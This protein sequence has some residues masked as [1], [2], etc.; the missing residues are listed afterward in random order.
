MLVLKLTHVSKSGPMCCWWQID[1]WQIKW[2]CIV[3]MYRNF[4]LEVISIEC[5]FEV[6][7]MVPT[8]NSLQPRVYTHSHIHTRARTR[9]HNTTQRTQHI[10][11][12]NTLNVCRKAEKDYYDNL[13]QEN[14]NDI[15]KSWKI[16]RS[17]INNKKN[18]NRNEIFHIENADVTDK[19]TIANKFNEFY[20]NIEAR[21][22]RNI[23]PGKCEPINYIKIGISNSIFIHPVN[24][25]EVVAILKE[26]KNSSPGWDCIS[27]KI[28]K[29]TYRCFLEPLVHITNMSILHGVFPDEL[30]IAKVL[31]LYKGGAS[32]LLVN[33]RPM[34]VL[35]VF[36][37]VL[38]RLMYNRI[39]EFIEENDVLY[40][41]QFGFRKNHSTAIVLTIVNDKISK[42]LY[43]G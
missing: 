38:E 8:D 5:W 29:Q 9:K 33:Y 26:M 1:V 12:H 3:V 14:K 32:K 37:E 36:S 42:A 27:P 40:N 17:I 24:E 20:V 28:V 6:W 23:P 31:P 41:F 30:K 13:F 19:Q 18:S 2:V 21:L 34:S 10:I 25:S 22:A 35:P 15:V 4:K 7:I 16:I 11:F 39:N 43:D